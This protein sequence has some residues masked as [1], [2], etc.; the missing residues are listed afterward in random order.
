MKRELRERARPGPSGEEAQVR[1]GDKVG[2]PAI[3]ARASHS[4]ETTLIGG[5]AKEL[6][7][8]EGS[9]DEVKERGGT[10]KR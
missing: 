3:M 2:R 7:S 10:A 4:G 5:K 8:S 9:P 1:R 6:A